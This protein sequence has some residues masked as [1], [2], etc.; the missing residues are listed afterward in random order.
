MKNPEPIKHAVSVEQTS[1]LWRQRKGMESFLREMRDHGARQVE[2]I[3][4]LR[5][6]GGLSLADAK[7]LVHFSQTWADMQETSEALHAAA[8]EAL[9]QWAREGEPERVAS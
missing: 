6:L 3:I 8:Y 9:E 7:K 2:S 4:A 1:L 5:E